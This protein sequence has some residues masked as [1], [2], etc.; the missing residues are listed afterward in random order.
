M[1]KQLYALFGNPVSHSKSPLLHN[2][3]FKHLSINACYTRYLLEDGAL[4]KDKFF[5]LGLHGANITVPFKENAY[6]ACDEI[7]EYAKNIGAVNTIIKKNEKLCGYNT[8]APGFLASLDG[9]RPKNVLILGAGGTARAIAFA[10]KNEGI[11]V[12]IANRSHG[13]LEFFMQ[14]GFECDVFDHLNSDLKFDLVVNTTSAGLSAEELP[15]EKEKLCALL[16]NTKLVYDC[17]YKE[18][19]FLHLAKELNIEAKNGLDMLIW[20]A[21]FAFEIFIGH[22]VDSKLIGI[23]KEA[24]K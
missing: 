7:D 2:S 24:V 17:I 4:L 22:E 12:T 20:Q 18:T 21:F 6:E 15:C 16:L 11:K 23:M 3:L 19:P 5:S 9:F 13:R 8:D 1:N 10:L 14:H